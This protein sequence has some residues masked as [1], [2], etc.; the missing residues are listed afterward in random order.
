MSLNDDLNNIMTQLPIAS[1]AY[2]RI[3]LA[4]PIE[5]AISHAGL[6]FYNFLYIAS[7]GPV[8]IECPYGRQDVVRNQIAI[9]LLNTNL[10]HV[11][12][13][14]VDHKHPTDIIQKFA[15]W[16][17]IN[18]NALVISGMNFRRG[19]PYDPV[20]GELTVPGIRRPI[21]TEWEPGLQEMGEIGAASLFIH[22]SVFERIE[23]PWFFNTYEG[24]WSN[25]LPGEDIGFSHKCADAGIQVYVDT[26]ITSPHCT[27][28]LVTERTFRAFIEA[29]PERFSG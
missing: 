16:A 13:L 19:E 15:K 7:Q 10:T 11:L 22:R 28:T 1:W 21:L 29:H 12:M 24:M 5:R 20:M 17:I 3:G 14:D 8:F 18:P 25:S 2:P 27:D 26:D 4:I 9:Q 23:P 6:V